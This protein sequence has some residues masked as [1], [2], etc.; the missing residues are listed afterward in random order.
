MRPRATERRG[1]GTES[2]RCVAV[3]RGRGG[4]AV[5]GLKLLLEFLGAAGFASHRRL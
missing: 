1:R 5:G 3:D 2:E 4:I